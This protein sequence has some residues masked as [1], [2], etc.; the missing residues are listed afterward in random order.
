MLVIL[1]GNLASAQFVP[2]LLENASYWG[3]GKSE[4][5]FYQAEFARDGERVQCEVIMIL[6]PTFVDP[7]TLAQVPDNKQPGALPAIRMTHTGTIPR[8]LAAE[9]RSIDALW[10]MDSMSLARLSF[11]GSD[12]FGNIA[13]NI[14]EKR[15]A[16]GVTWSYMGDVYN[17]RADPQSISL[18][19]KTVVAYDELPLRMRTL[20]FG[21][22]AGD[23]EIELAPS[24]VSPTKELGEFK[25][26][27]VRWEASERT[28]GVELQHSLGKDSFTLDSNFPFLLREW[29]AWDGTHWKMKNSIRA[30]YRKYLKKGDRDRAFKDPMLR[31]PD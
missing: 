26:A 25:P 17:G 14:R 6:T 19:G 10:R 16:S 13:K 21:K 30:D 18:G 7:S 24:L 11:S 1:S 4:I 22:P 31:H 29:Q 2:A 9:P 15:D 28:I 27:K 8:G 3:D 20:D 5:D 12:V 23:S